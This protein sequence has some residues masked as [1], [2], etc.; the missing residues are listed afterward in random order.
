MKAVAIVD[1]LNLYHALKDL[2]ANCNNLDV[3]R[4]GRRLLPKDV[5]DFQVFYFT[6]PPE[7]LGGE[8]LKAYQRHARS[9]MKCGV[10][11][12]EGRFQKAFTRCK[13]CG[14]LNQSHIE[15]ETD[16]SIALKI[17]ESAA[18]QQTRQILL[19]S[20]DSDLSPALKL[21][22]D[23]NPEV[24]IS[25]VQT[26]AYIAKANSTLMSF[27][28]DKYELRLNFVHNYQFTVDK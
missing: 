27:A 1:G 7:H 14:A 26:A 5:G 13:V 11:I 18:N 17:V 24:K 12:V 28:D 6:T 2:G 25:I 19:F 22:K 21:A 10:E 4:L 20:A 16:V 3:A 23:T 15:K 9:L 8:S